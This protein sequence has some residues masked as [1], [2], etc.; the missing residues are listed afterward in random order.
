[1]KIENFQPSLGCF[2]VLIILIQWSEWVGER[3]ELYSSITLEKEDTD[4]E[5]RERL[6][7]WK[8]ILLGFHFAN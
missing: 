6:L 8:L 4:E 1:M 3:L 5:K 7:K 2:D